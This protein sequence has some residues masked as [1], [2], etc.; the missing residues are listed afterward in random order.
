MPVP[1]IVPSLVGIGLL[2]G[3]LVARLRT[4]ELTRATSPDAPP[5][6][7]CDASL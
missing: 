7:R 1:L 2:C 5:P 3:A 4:R 6:Y